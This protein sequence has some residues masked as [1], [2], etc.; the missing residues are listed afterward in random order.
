MPGSAASFDPVY[1]RLTRLLASHVRD[2]AV[3]VAVGYA[4]PGFAE[5]APAV[6]RPE[7]RDL[8]MFLRRRGV[9]ALFACGFLLSVAQSA[10]LA[11]LALYATESF[12]LSAIAAGWLLWIYLI[13]ILM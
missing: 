8:G 11:Y 3:V 10:L 4:R 1:G 13:R 9:Q 5:A 7:L 2:G 6:P 12:A